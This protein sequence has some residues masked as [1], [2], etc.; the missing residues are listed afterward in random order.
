[1]NLKQSQYNNKDYIKK[2]NKELILSKA[3]SYKILSKNTISHHQ[4]RTDRNYIT[5][6]IISKINKN[7]LLKY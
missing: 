2:H 1:M 7:G 5:D 3:D 6:D 4:H